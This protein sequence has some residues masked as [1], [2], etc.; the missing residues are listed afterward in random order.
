MRRAWLAVSIALLLPGCGAGDLTMPDDFCFGFCGFPSN[1]APARF[2]QTPLLIP[3]DMRVGDTL[4]V[5]V[6]FADPASTGA[7]TWLAPDPSVA[8]WDVPSPACVRDR[9]QIL[10]AVGRGWTQVTVT[11]PCS[12]GQS[13]GCPATISIT[14]IRVTDRMV[15][16]PG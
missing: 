14:T 5:E 4:R 13:Y 15:K 7:V 3:N 10:R 1:P 11:V 12:E 16:Y 2:H 9:C 6:Q 8:T